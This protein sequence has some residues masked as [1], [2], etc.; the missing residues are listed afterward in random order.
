VLANERPFP[1]NP[2]NLERFMSQSSR[3]VLAGL[4]TIVISACVGDV[5]GTTATTGVLDRL[6]ASMSST[7]AGG[8][9]IQISGSASSG[10]VPSGGGFTF[11]F[12]V[13]NVGP[14]SATGTTL[15]DVLPGGTIFQGAELDGNVLSCTQADA[16]VL[17]DLG[18]FRKSGQGT[19]LFLVNA[20]LTPG[21]TYVNAATVTSA[22]ADPQPSNNS[23]SVSFQ[24][25]AT[26]TGG[27]GGGGGPVVPTAVSAFSSLPADFNGGGYIFAGGPSGIATEFTATATGTLGSLIIAMH[28]SGTPGKAGFWLYADDVNNPGHPGAL[29]T[30]LFAQIP[31]LNGSYTFISVPKA[32]APVLVAGHQY[33]LFGF[34]SAGE[35][36]AQ[37]DRTLNLQ[38]V[39]PIASGIPGEIFVGPGL[40]VMPAFQVVVLQ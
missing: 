8:A 30:N 5:A 33:W 31:P 6:H 7:V 11:T 17:C 16:T 24:V 38:Q 19:V 20:P 13:R 22:V 1:R 3:F 29:L 4:A 32:L 35:L 21:A 25:A 18:T 28:A 34:G 12:K 36:S 37:W 27:G 39:A 9:D 26:A 10:S 15:R 40:A 23:V 14:D 2:I